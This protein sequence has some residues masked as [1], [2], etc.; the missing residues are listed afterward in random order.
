MGRAAERSPEVSF[1]ASEGVRAWFGGD[2]GAV[3]GRRDMRARGIRGGRERTARS[4]A[5]YKDLCMVS[6]PAPLPVSRAR[7][8][9]ALYFFRPRERDSSGRASVQEDNGIACKREKAGQVKLKGGWRTVRRGNNEPFEKYERLRE[10]IKATRLL[11][12]L[13]LANLYAKA[14]PLN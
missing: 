4:S 6:W 12:G 14:H 11:N 10:T 5:K 3:R 7:T 2:G 13:E 9:A 8:R 1:G